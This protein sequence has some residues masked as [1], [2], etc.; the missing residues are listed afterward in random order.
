MAPNLFAVQG[1]LHARHQGAE[2]QVKVSRVTTL[3]RPPP[4]PKTSPWPQAPA[5]QGR[6]VGASGKRSRPPTPAQPGLGSPRARDHAPGVRAPRTHTRHR[7]G[8]PAS[9]WIEAAEALLD[10]RRQARSDKLSTTDRSEIRR[11]LRAISDQAG[12]PRRR[13]AGRCP[14][15]ERRSLSSVRH[16]TSSASRAGATASARSPRARRDL[17]RVPGRRCQ[18]RRRSSLALR[19]S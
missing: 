4:P 15:A 8:T 5:P 1:Q 10:Q 18:R 17:R 2:Y 11:Q 6:E 14:R 13:L 7:E 12:S 19:A 16:S 9:T 3:T